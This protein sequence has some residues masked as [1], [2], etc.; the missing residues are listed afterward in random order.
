MHAEAERIHLRE[1]TKEREEA[2]EREVKEEVVNTSFFLAWVSFLLTKPELFK[3]IFG[4]SLPMFESLWCEVNIY[5]KETPLL[6]TSEKRRVKEYLLSDYFQFLLCLYVLRHAPTMKF[7]SSWM[8]MSEATIKRYVKRV[9]LALDK[10]LGGEIKWPSDKEFEQYKK[11][12][13]LPSFLSDLVC[14]VDGFEIKIYKPKEKDI[15]KKHKSGKKKQYSLNVMVVVLLNGIIIFL[16]EPRVG[17]HD[18]SHWNEL[19]LRQRFEKK[20]M[21]WWVM[22][23]FSSI[24]RKIGS[25]SKDGSLYPIKQ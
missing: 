13:H 4:L 21:E 1:Q 8:G 20:R 2:L 23:V 3:Y 11:L 16:S 12:V 22:E 9:L 10:V 6:P 24:E 15:A 18:Q 14:A 17:A 25:K 7:L 5:L 19:K